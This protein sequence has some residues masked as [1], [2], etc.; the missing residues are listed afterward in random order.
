MAPV[1]GTYLFEIGG[2]FVPYFTVSV[3]L[4]GFQ[5][6]IL[7]FPSSKPQVKKIGIDIKNES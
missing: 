6:A 3:L 4:F 5:L 2:I 1:L 7:D